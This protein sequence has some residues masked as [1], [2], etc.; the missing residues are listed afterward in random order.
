MDYFSEDPLISISTE[1]ASSSPIATPKCGNRFCRNADLD[2]LSP[3][4]FSPHG[5]GIGER[6]NTTVGDVIVEVCTLFRSMSLR[7]KR[8]LETYLFRQLIRNNVRDVGFLKF[9]GKDF[10]DI[11]V[12]VTQK[13]YFAGKNNLV[14]LLSQCFQ[15]PKDEPKSATAT[16][17]H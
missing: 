16:R 12:Q 11:S 14:Y 6:S 13:L 5:K 8:Q 17:L 10:L 3:L 7:L 15:A 1:P 4:F 9:V 2:S